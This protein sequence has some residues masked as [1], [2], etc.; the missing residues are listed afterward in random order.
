MRLQRIGFL[1]L[2]LG[3]ITGWLTSA[4]S[5]ATGQDAATIVDFES[6]PLGALARTIAD[7]YQPNTLVTFTSA[8]PTNGVNVV[9]L[10]KNNATSVC[11]E[12]ADAN[13]K[14][15]SGR[16]NFSDG[17]IGYGTAAIRATFAQPLA[18]P[19]VISVDFQ[20]GAGL[21]VRLRLFDASGV[22]IAAVTE[23]ATESAGTCG[24]PGQPRARKRLTLRAEQPVAAAV[25]DMGADTG[26][27]VFTI[28][29]FSYGP[30]PLDDPSTGQGQ[31]DLA[32]AVVDTPT[33]VRAGEPFTYTLH[34]TNR[35]P[36]PATAVVLTQTLT[37]GFTLLQTIADQA[38]C[39]PTT[40]RLRCTLP[41]LA[42]NGNTQVVLTLAAHAERSGQSV[43]LLTTV[44]DLRNQDPVPDNNSVT[45]VL[46]VTSGR[47]TNGLQA[48]YTFGETEPAVIY[49]LSGIGA[50]LNLTVPMPAEVQK[51]LGGLKIITP[52][53]ITSASAQKLRDGIVTTGEL[54]VELW[55]APAAQSA[56]QPAHLLTL[57]GN[58]TTPLLAL[59]QEP[60]SNQAAGLYT[61]QLLTNQ[62]PTGNRLS[63]TPATNPVGQRLHLVYTRNAAGLARLY[64]NGTAQAAKAMSGDLAGWAAQPVLRLA[65]GPTGEQPWVGEVQLLAFYNRALDAN[66]VQQNYRHGPHGDGPTDDA[67]SGDDLFGYDYEV[68][69]DPATPFAG[70]AVKLGAVVHRLA[71]KQVLSDV[72]VRF[73]LGDPAHGGQRLGDALVERLSPR[74]SALSSDV[75]WT[76]PAAGTYSLYIQLDPQNRIGE[77]DERNNLL[78]RTVTVRSPATTPNADLVAP[79]VDAFTIGD[80]QASTSNRNVQLAVTVSDPA[81][82]AGIAGVAFVEYAYAPDAGAWRIVQS[83]DWLPYQAAPAHYDWQLQATPG[84]KYIQAWAKD[85]AGNISLFPYTRYINY[86]PPVLQVNQESIQILRFGVQAG[87]RL[88]IRLIAQ[89]GDPD[90][91]LWPPDHDQGRPPWVSNLRGAIDAV[92][93][94]APVTGNYQIEIY[95]FTFAEYQLQ[96]IQEPAPTVAAGDEGGID[97]SKVRFIQPWVKLTSAP[98]T[99]QALL[100]LTGQGYKTFLPLIHE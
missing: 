11:T 32:L 94:V 82:T 40:G 97:P 36:K 50:P 88:T 75:T 28:D 73:Y 10:V 78:V 60:Y 20:T 58:D 67:D 55:I 53:L 100:L 25:M 12:P 27:F 61:A 15:G 93:L 64:L 13:Q 92:S 21:P 1:L 81:P 43:T 4:P 65:T 77:T 3:L 71:G 59:L 90:L 74:S 49:D 38:L 14:F 29:T 80:G 62:T 35:G 52:T 2:I 76:P 8:T 18:P 57:V 6:P 98:T 42:V 86:A 96:I 24:L 31:S 56:A 83:S 69:V 54:S 85:K 17:A 23:S 39:Q 47:V 22:E 95:G 34:L 99:N 68:W 84:L 87:D 46:P 66:E 45:T 19:Q 9:G 26:R 30:A 91:Y 63:A 37:S 72:A 48:F 7:P 51:T 16:S 5:T 44:A 33:A 70:T 41:S 89:R 79:H